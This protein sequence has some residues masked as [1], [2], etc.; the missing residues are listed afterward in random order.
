[1]PAGDLLAALLEAIAPVAPDGDRAARTR[2]RIMVGLRIQAPA[3]ASYHTVPADAGV[4]RSLDAG[5]E[6]KFLYKDARATSL[7]LRLKPGARLPAHVHAADEECLVL[8][9]ELWLGE[10][11]RLQAGDYH[12]A[13]K[14][15]PHAAA[16]S[17]MGALLFL[18]SEKPAY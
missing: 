16:E 4:W 18:R 9:G 8:E 2:E 13:P 3:G 12:F 14:G 5:L 11:V 15:L 1:M 17:P 10:G 7:L 6:V